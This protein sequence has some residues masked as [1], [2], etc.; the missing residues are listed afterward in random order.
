MAGALVSSK[1]NRVCSKGDPCA[2]SGDAFRA[3]EEPPAAEKE[4]QRPVEEFG[5]PLCGL[6]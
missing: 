3:G 5:L 6:W 2:C 4:E 1:I